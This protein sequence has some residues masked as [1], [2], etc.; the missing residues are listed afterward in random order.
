MRQFEDLTKIE[1]SDKLKMTGEIM[2]KKRGEKNF[3]FALHPVKIK[4]ERLW[5]VRGC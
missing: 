5:G 4:I 1:D 3:T 2:S